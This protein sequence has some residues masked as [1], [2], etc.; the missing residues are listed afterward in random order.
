MSPERAREARKPRPLGRSFTYADYLELRGWE[1]DKFRDM[2][3]ITDEELAGTDWAEL[4]ADL[5]GFA[6]SPLDHPQG[7]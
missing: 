3:P 5:L 6:S 2:P 4:A 1:F 7:Q